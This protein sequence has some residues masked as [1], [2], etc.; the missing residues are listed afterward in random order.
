MKQDANAKQKIVATNGPSRIEERNAVCKESSH[1]SARR[2]VSE[3]AADLSQDAN[4]ATLATSL[5]IDAQ[6]A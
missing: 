2:T 1:R 3:R 4:D 6:Q 5:L